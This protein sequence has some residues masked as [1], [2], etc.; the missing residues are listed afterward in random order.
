MDEERPDFDTL[1]TGEASPGSSV[2]LE[3]PTVPGGVCVMDE[4]KAQ[5]VAELLWET[6]ENNET[7]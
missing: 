2:K 4:N 7:W 3:L 1:V 5:T 6:R